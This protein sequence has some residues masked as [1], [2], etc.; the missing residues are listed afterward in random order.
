[1]FLVAAGTVVT[2]VVV[3]SQVVGAQVL[4]LDERG[5]LLECSM[6]ELLALPEMMTFAVAHVASFR[7]F[8]WSVRLLCCGWDRHVRS[9]LVPDE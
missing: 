1:M 3:L 8:P 4:L 2:L 7:R 6:P 9:S 5:S